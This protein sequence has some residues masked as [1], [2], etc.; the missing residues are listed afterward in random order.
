MKAP[1][2]VLLALALTACSHKADTSHS[3]RHYQVTGKVVALNSRDQT[4]TVDAAAVPNFM[5]AMTMD[6]PVKSKDEFKTLHVGDQ[7]KATID[8]SD[9]GVYD[10]SKIQVQ[11]PGK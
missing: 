1:I 4:A 5:E 10:L 9:A 7:I 11:N 8:V 3:E 2:P 6:Y